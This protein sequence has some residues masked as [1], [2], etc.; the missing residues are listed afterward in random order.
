MW[1]RWLAGVSL[2]APDAAALDRL[3]TQLGDDE[4]ISHLLH[5]TAI[6]L[7]RQ[8]TIEAGLQSVQTAAAMAQRV[9]SLRSELLALEVLAETYCYLGNTAGAI[10]VA[11]Q[12]LA[13]S[14]RLEHGPAGVSL[15]ALQVLATA[16][17]L[18]GNDE[19]A[20]EAAQ[21][22]VVISHPSNAGQR[23]LHLSSWTE[24][25]R[26]LLLFGQSNL[27]PNMAVLEA[28]RPV[29]MTCDIT[30]LIVAGQAQAQRG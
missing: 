25:H 1:S 14:S 12:A 9:G 2:A 30:W 20:M 17:W 13:I 3:V 21:R 10:K 29:C 4:V 28:D 22:L 27:L 8:G 18:A 24:A 23:P 15:P 6:S 5:I 7:L 11:E 19:A 16:H 26:A